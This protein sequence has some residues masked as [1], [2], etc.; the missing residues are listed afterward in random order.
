M[1]DV[2]RQLEFTEIFGF[3]NFYACQFKHGCGTFHDSVDFSVGKLRGD[4]SKNLVDHS[5]LAMSFTNDMATSCEVMDKNKC[6]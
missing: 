1:V 4:D 2:V 3:L 6:G 5:D